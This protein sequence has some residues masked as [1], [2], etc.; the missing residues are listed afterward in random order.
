MCKIGGAAAGSGDTVN[1]FGAETG[2]GHG[3]ECRIGM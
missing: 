2:V 1:V 3:I